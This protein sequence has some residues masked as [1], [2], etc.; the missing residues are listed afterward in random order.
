MKPLL[1]TFA[2]ALALLPASLGAQEATPPANPLIYDDLAMHFEAPDGWVSAGQQKIDL[3]DLPEDPT[4]VAAWF[5]RG[6]DRPTKMVLEM[7][8]FEGSLDAFEESVEQQVRGAT[9]DGVVRSKERT[10]LK[11]GMPAYFIGVVSGSGFDTTKSFLV[12]WADGQRGVEIIITAQVGF[13]DADSA[14]KWL[15]NLSAVQFPVDRL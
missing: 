10:T 5:R 8:H 15:S 12:A 13:I 4:A 6:G 1:A 9:A 11:N 7:Q 2:I 14:K 3:K